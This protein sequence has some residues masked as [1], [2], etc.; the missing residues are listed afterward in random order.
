MYKTAKRL[1]V[2][3]LKIGDYISETQYYRVLKIIKPSTLSSN[4][5]VQLVNDRGMKLSIDSNIL[6]EGSY[7][8][9]QVF[10]IESLSRTDLASVLES[11]KSDIFTVCFDKQPNPETLI[12]KLK[13]TS[14]SIL[15]E[16]K[17]LK[18]LAKDLLQGEERILVGHLFNSEPKMG[19]SLVV[20]LEAEDEHPV[21]M[22][23]HR[24]IKWIILRGKQY[25]AV[26]YVKGKKKGIIS[27]KDIKI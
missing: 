25:V 21:R 4:G 9:D 3:S 18:S 15:S 2:S 13:D 22:V 16:N 27:K 1:H 26:D 20:D 19:R 17:T 24:T 11:A 14:F 23:D 12:Q 5:E 7:S 10:E 6:E 8:A